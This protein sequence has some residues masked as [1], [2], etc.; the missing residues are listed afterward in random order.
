MSSAVEI[1]RM[2]GLSFLEHKWKRQLDVS[3]QP[4]RTARALLENS[5]LLLV[6]FVKDEK[7]YDQSQVFEW[8][9]V[10]IYKAHFYRP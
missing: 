4:Y 7:N 2:Y 3:F 10:T 6:K 5:Q 8:A 9:D 1:F